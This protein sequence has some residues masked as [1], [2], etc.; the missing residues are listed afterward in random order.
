VN[1]VEICTP[2]TVAQFAMTLLESREGNL[3]PEQ[4]RQIAG[5]VLSQPW[6]AITAYGVGKKRKKSDSVICLNVWWYTR[7]R[8]KS[9]RWDTCY[10][11]VNA[12]S[13]GIVSREPRETAGEIARRN[14]RVIWEM[15]FPERVV[16]LAHKSA[17]RVLKRHGIARPPGTIYA[18]NDVN[19]T[20]RL[21]VVETR[22][23]KRYLCS[24]IGAIHLKH[25][26][27]F[28][29]DALVQLNAVPE[30]KWEDVEPYLA[31]AALA[32]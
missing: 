12:G 8:Q 14:R 1:K 30:F 16:A 26:P 22:D 15:V 21:A 27:R 11:H 2:A 13:F 32:Q 31:M 4:V 9:M 3:S 24:P 23:A 19:S 5:A 28:V 7:G 25:S 18:L 10:T 29:L 17:C 6:G 20:A